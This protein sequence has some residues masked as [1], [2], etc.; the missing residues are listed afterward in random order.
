MLQQVANAETFGAKGAILFSDPANYAPAGVDDTFPKS[1]WLPET[2]SQR[3]SIMAVNG[4]PLTPDLPSREG[5]YRI[6][7]NKVK[8]IPGIPAQ[9]MGYGDVIKLL[10]RMKGNKTGS[11]S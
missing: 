8:G 3:G 7:M 9:P 4:D 1:W 2:G 11:S 6:P 5:I 10:S